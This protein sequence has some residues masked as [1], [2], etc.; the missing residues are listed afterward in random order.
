MDK[1]SIKGIDQSARPGDKPEVG[2]PCKTLSTI[3]RVSGAPFASSSIP[4]IP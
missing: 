3:R 2:A 4:A 1:V